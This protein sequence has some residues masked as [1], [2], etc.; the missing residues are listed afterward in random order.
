MNK[1][2]EQIVLTGLFL[3]IGIIL[4]P[5]F[6]SVGMGE[7]ISPMHFPV[8]L[9]GLL[10]GWKYGIICGFLTPLLAGLMWGVPQQPMAT[11][12]AFEL[13]IYGL[14]TGLLYKKLKLFK[15]SI[16]NLYFALIIAMV[17]GRAV[18]GLIN[19]LL[20]LLDISKLGFIAFLTG[21]FVTGLPGIILQ[22]LIIPAIIVTIE[23]RNKF[24]EN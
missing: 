6:H 14:I 17:A 16:I 2:I 23:N 11:I 8:L 9:C 19:G 24:L 20:F 10:L 7:I 21:I 1:N 4:P 18:F 12:M 22:I 13:A 3:A 15:N 5:L